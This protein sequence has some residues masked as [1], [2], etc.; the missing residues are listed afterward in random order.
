MIRSFSLVTLAVA[1]AIIAAGCDEGITRTSS[2]DIYTEP[3]LQ[4]GADEIW[5][6]SLVFDRVPQGRSD[7]RQLVVGQS[8][9]DTLTISRIYIE[10]FEDCDRI[11][12]G[13]GPMDPFPGELDAQC[14][15]SISAGA[16]TPLEL[17][18][19]AFRTYDLTYK[20]IDP[21]NP[22]PATLVI[23]S[24][25]LDKAR[26][27]VG[28]N[29]VSASP[30]IVAFPTTIAFPGGVDGQDVLQVRN[31]GS[32]PLFVSNFRVR[33]LNDAPLDEQTG[34]PLTEFVVDPDRELP[35]N[36]E[37]DEVLQVV[38]RYTP[39]DDGADNAEI[40]FQ[41]DDPTNPELSVFLTSSQVSSTLVVQPNPMVFG[42]PVGG[43]PAVRPLSL[44]NSGLQT[45]F[46]NGM[47][48]EDDSDAYRINDQ[49][50]FQILPGQNRT[51]DITYT[52]RSAEGSDASL[53]IRT[54]ADNVAGGQMVVPLLRS[55]AEIAALEISPITADLS[56]VD[57]GASGA[58]TVTLS[59]PGGQPL[60][61]QRI[62]MTTEADAPL[63]PS[64][65][66]FAVTSGGGAVTIPPEGMHTVE[67]TFS[68][69]A[70]DRNM[71]IGTLIVE[72]DAATSP[73][74][75]RFTSRP[76]AE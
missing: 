38:V 21:A 23:E 42:Q 22:Q 30:R 43:N 2:A 68:R 70:D 26:V 32:G 8:G 57:F 72:S 19:S 34:E 15:W 25:A 18:E 7:V 28:L 1:G 74:V 41:S 50:S 13:I 9:E 45:L 40:I 63:V 14:T 20:A 44:R 11:A 56:G 76:P 61:V 33:R 64:D 46:I 59:N 48:I 17:S 52:P 49:T 39:Q 35:W 10:G 73:D 16:A 65:P 12:A 55:A 37:Q 6:T 58:V 66:E 71:H 54:D 53:V 4:P 36:L 47:D 67:V 51:V 3:A 62:E 31:S 60:E 5:R 75:V 29:V 27:E 69:G 24:N